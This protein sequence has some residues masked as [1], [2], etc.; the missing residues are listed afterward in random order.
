M[1]RPLS[2]P[3]QILLPGFAVSAAS[4]AAWVAA[5]VPDVEAAALEALAVFGRY[6]YTLGDLDFLLYDAADS[7]PAG[8]APEFLAALD[9]LSRLR[10]A[11]I[12][13]KQP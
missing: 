10:E 6:G 8:G 9:L 12:P 1:N 4:A 7:D 2:W 5:N 11:G 13:I 3:Q